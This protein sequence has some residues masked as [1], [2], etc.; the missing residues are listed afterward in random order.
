MRCKEASQQLQLYLDN[1]LTI[2]QIRTLEAHIASC[3]ACLEELTIFETI[4]ND[5]ETFKVV[6]EPD[7]LNVQIM[8]RV[9]IAAS[10]RNP[11]SSHISLWPPSLLEILVAAA[12]ATIATIGTILQQPSIRSMLP[13]VNGHDGLSLAY[14]SMLHALMNVDSTTLILALWIAGTILGVC[15]TLI[16]AGSEIRTQWF[17]A[18]MERLPVR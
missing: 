2:E 12:L 3:N 4:V 13:F 1:R 17:K 10:Q 6:A 7:D 15:I 18:M 11:S 14:L 5:L 8:R 16:F 9:A